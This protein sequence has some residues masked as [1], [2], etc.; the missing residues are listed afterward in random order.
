MGIHVLLR[1]GE[2]GEALILAPE[3]FDPR[4]TVGTKSAR[5]L[6]EIAD[7]VQENVTAR[8][9]AKNRPVLVLD[10]THAYEGFVV[11]RHDPAAPGEI[12]SAKHASS[13]KA[14]IEIQAVIANLTAEPSTLQQVSE[15]QTWLGS[16]D[17]VNDVCELAD[18]IRTPLLGALTQ[19]RES[20]A[21]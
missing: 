12:A 1:A 3:R 19:L 2:L 20:L 16:D 7:I 17:V 15:L 5:R 6:S 8:S 4:R 11:L 14:I 9:F 21:A 18:D 13:A 10:T